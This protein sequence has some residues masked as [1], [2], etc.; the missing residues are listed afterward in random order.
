[1][2]HQTLTIIGGAINDPD[3]RM[4]LP[5]IEAYDRLNLQNY[6]FIDSNLTEHDRKYI[7]KLIEYIASKLCNDDAATIQDIT[8][9]FT[10]QL[11]EFMSNP[12]FK[13]LIIENFKFY[14]MGMNEFVEL[15]GHVDNSI[16][17]DFTGCYTPIEMCKNHNITSYSKYFIHRNFFVVK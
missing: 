2:T 11:D 12:Q 1:M 15:V 5:Q 8:D 9:G 10:Q 16:I 7:S 4:Q 13:I 3:Y 6:N 14:K 17:I